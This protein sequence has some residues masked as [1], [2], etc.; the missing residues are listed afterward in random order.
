L[1]TKTSWAKGRIQEGLQGE[2]TQVPFRHLIAT[3][4]MELF[5]GNGCKAGEQSGTSD[6]FK[7]PF[8]GSHKEGRE[9]GN[10]RHGGGPNPR[11]RGGVPQ[12]R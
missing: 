4:T 5:E 1:S 12:L 8:K 2:H 7:G 10:G 9:K 11:D 3:E 6:L